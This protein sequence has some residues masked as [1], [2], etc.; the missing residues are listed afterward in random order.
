MPMILML[1]LNCLSKLPTSACF[2]TTGFDISHTTRFA[3]LSPI[4]PAIASIFYLL[5]RCFLTSH[6]PDREYPN[7]NFALQF[8][9]DSNWPSPKPFGLSRRAN[10]IHGEPTPGPGRRSDRS[11]KRTPER[12]PQMHSRTYRKKRK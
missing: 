7:L 12:R 8:S 9:L 4:F 1:D 5:T 3:Y 6:A 2:A 11:Q 10:K